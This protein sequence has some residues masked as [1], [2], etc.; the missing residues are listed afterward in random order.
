MPNK[1]LLQTTLEIGQNT[2][3]PAVHVRQVQGVAR[4]LDMAVLRALNEVGVLGA[5]RDISEQRRTVGAVKRS[6]PSRLWLDRNIRT[7]SQMRSDETLGRDILNGIFCEICS[8]RSGWQWQVG[9]VSERREKVNASNSNFGTPSAYGR[10]F[11]APIFFRF[12]LWVR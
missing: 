9:Q 1:S 12:S 8:D 10:P 2:H 5:C 6:A 11:P 7:T 4:E 3:L